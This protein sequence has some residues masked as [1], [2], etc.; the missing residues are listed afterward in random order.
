MDTIS[1]EVFFPG[2]LQ[3][4]FRSISF[5]Q[6]CELHLHAETTRETPASPGRRHIMG[7]TGLFIS[8]TMKRPSN[9]VAA[10]FI[11]HII[12]HTLLLPCPSLR[13]GGCKNSS[14]LLHLCASCVYSQSGLLSLASPSLL[15][16]TNT[17]ESA[18]LS[19]ATTATTDIS[20]SQG[21]AST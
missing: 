13:T 3:G 5:S 7:A 16:L 15:L 19:V 21:K 1:S 2:S 17:G 9:L 20:A 6:L 4:I 14:L 11:S 10:L 12:A 18:Q 8:E